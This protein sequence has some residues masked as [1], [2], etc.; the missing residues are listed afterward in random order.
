VIRAGS[1]WRQS[2]WSVVVVERV[3]HGGRRR[4]AHARHVLRETSFYPDTRRRSRTVER[5][6]FQRASR[7]AVKIRRT[8]E[9]AARGPASRRHEGCGRRMAADSASTARALQLAI[10]GA[11]A[12]VRCA[13]CGAVTTTRVCS[14]HPRHRK[15]EAK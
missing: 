9:D 7:A 4:A 14:Q 6:D 11:R 2:A 12:P 8:A 5:A 3:V 13:E 10:A 15:R 1:R